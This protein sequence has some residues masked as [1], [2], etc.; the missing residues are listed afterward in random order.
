MD[1][2]NDGRLMENYQFGRS[3][4][5]SLGFRRMQRLRLPRAFCHNAEKVW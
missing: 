3:R 5:G 1:A 4:A 2:V